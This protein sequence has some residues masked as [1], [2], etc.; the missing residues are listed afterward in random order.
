[1]KTALTLFVAL[2]ALP[3]PAGAAREPRVPRD[4]STSFQEVAHGFESV[5]WMDDT[6]RLAEL[7]RLDRALAP[8]LRDD[9]DGR[10]RGTAQLLSGSIR[11]ERGD[12]A[13]AGEAF[14]EAARR[15]ADGPFADDAEFAQIR[16]LEARGQDADAAR[17]WVKWEKRWPSSPLLSEA[18][19]AEGWNALRRGDAAEADRALTAMVKASP[20]ATSD[21]RVAL[22][23]ATARH[24][25]G[26]TADALAILGPHPTGAAALYLQG[27]CFTATGSL[28]RA[29]AA[30]QEVADRYPGSRLRDPALLAKANAFLTAKD[31][32]SAA[33]EFAR[34]ADR[35]TDPDLKAEAQLRAAGSV[36]LSGNRDSAD[37][38][39][40]EM[41][42]RNAGSDVA[43]RAQFLVGEIAVAQQR[44]GD[45]IVEYNRVLKDYFRHEV[46]AS[47]QYRV[48]RCLDAMNRPADATG[49]YEA[50]VRGYPLSPEAPAAAYLA[51]VGL[52][53]QKKPLAAAPYFQLVLDRYASRNDAKGLV[54][55]ASPAH[56]EI[57]EAALCLLELS[58]R[59]AG[60]LGQLS[61][62]PHLL[63]Q[64]MPPSH[65]PWRAWAV[66]IDADAAASQGRYP[67]AQTSLEGLERDWPDQPVGASATQLLAWTYARQGRDS[68]A[69][70]TEE[71]LLARHGS[72]DQARIAG[73]LLD[74]AHERFNQKRYR[75]AAG[76][77]EDFVR[78][79]PDHPRRLLALYQAGLCYSRL[80]RTGDAV[81]RWTQITRDSATAPI[82]ERA[83]AR[84]GDLYFQASHYDDAKRCYE[85]LLKN[86]AGTSAG[87]L[88]TLRLGQCEYNAG[89]DATALAR[90]SETQEKYAGTPIAKEAQ[91][92]TEL[93]LYRLSQSPDGEKEL[94]RLVEQFPSSAFA[95][96]AQFKLAQRAYAKKH[97]DEAADGFR[98]VV[99][100]FPSYSAADQAQFLMADALAQSG[101]NADARL[102]S[103]QFLSFFPSSELRPTVQFRLGLMDF[104]GKEYA[105]AATAFTQVL[106]DSAKGEVARAAQFNLALCQRMLGDGEQARAGLEAYRARWGD[107]G[108]TAEIAVQLGDFDET[109]GRTQDAVHEYEHGLAASP[110]PRLATELAFRLGRCREALGQKIAALTSY[111]QAYRGRDR[112]DP[113]R[114]S[115]VARCAAL[116]ES[117]KRFALALEAYRDLMRN[118]KD[119]ELVAAATSRASQLE[120]SVRRH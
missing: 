67:E 59:R 54:V 110:S 29:A 22:A 106:S 86:F 81:D 89:H 15:G 55:F 46:A 16:S 61:G 88:A 69:I 4:A 105:R 91:R 116:Y 19:L 68:L 63:L 57:V 64:R 98:R 78:R 52:M 13:G 111:E 83:W 17:E 90:F 65:S 72:D 115:A 5:R 23:R 10:P 1:M 101:R 32:R 100:Q 25:A 108:R 114:L 77:Y 117:Q 33:S 43:A 2:V 30:F 28:L 8:F 62:A 73:A 113:F 84:A 92:G 94:A 47:A 95:A 112:D 60:N 3:A 14:G 102:A 56:Q 74:I 20:W 41:V 97:W 70:A 104:E 39:L 50:V 12:Y 87:A 103:E 51:G 119:R 99:S 53:G 21:P 36:F 26:N 34:A 11:F 58:Y 82:A 24:V 7:E 35:I 107:D 6:Q 38:A 76:A 96:D 45:A 27:V 42:A 85:G 71:R 80:E 44:Y 40:R 93:A 66:L 109:A 31:W 9:V 79:Y 18:R 118:A 49:S 75:E 37:A 48:A 120:A